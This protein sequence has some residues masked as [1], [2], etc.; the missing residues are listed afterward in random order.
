M[1]R[2]WAED[3]KDLL[4]IYFHNLNQK[5]FMSINKEYSLI[6]Y[7]VKLSLPE[8]TLED[9]FNDDIVLEMAANKLKSDLEKEG[10]EVWKM[11]RNILVTEEGYKVIMYEDSI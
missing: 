11:D 7:T 9:M 8:E 1:S 4:E 3:G 6:I 2:G 10:V 5:I